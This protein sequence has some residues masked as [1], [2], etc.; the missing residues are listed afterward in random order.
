[1]TG[2]EIGGVT[3]F[4][5][6]AELP[7]WID[8][9][10]MDA[11]ADR[12]R[13]RQPQLEGHRPASILLTLPGAEVVEGLANPAPPPADGAARCRRRR[14]DH[15]WASR[16]ARG[17]RVA[18]LVRRL[19]GVIVLF[20]RRRRRSAAGLASPIAHG[21]GVRRRDRASAATDEPDA[22]S[23][24]PIDRATRPSRAERREPTAEADRCRRARPGRRSRSRR[25]SSTPGRPGRPRP[26]DHLQRPGRR[27]RSGA[28][29]VRHAAGEPDVPAIRRSA[30]RLP[31]DRRRLDHR[32]HV[33]QGA[34]LHAHAA[35]R[36]D[37]GARRR[38]DPDVPRASGPR[39]PS[40]TPASTARLPRDRTAS[41]WWSRRAPTATCG[42]SPSGAAIRSVYEIDLLGSRAGPAIAR[43]ARP[44]AGDGRRTPVRGDGAA[45]RGSL[46]LQNAETGFGITP[47]DRADHLA[48][49]SGPTGPSA[50]RV[51]TAGP[52]CGQRPSPRGWGPS[53]RSPMSRHVAGVPRPRS[54]S[55]NAHRHSSLSRHSPTA[56]MPRARV[57]ARRHGRRPPRALEPP[58]PLP[59]YHPRFVTET[60]E[61]PMIDCLWASGAMLL[62]KWTNGDIH[63][64][65]QRLRALSGDAP[66]GSEFSRPEDR[67]PQ[68]RLQPQ[69]LARWRRTGSRSPACSAARARAPA[70]SC[71]ATT[72]S[73]PATS[74][75]GTTRSGT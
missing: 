14:P 34:V 33:D 27:A 63:P 52:W 2:H 18:V 64:T 15:R 29:D 75:A 11:G 8:A 7:V 26:R 28:L 31:D 20:G 58:R 61:R 24:A 47:T 43:A 45:T 62:D 3:V 54:D 1:M 69:V 16:P 56:T 13:R 59:G 35:G 65:H 23:R 73:C 41:R 70:R 51:G 12:A 60:D 67:L 17:R 57:A 21:A 46:V 44:G 25:S 9:A 48:L 50:G 39:S 72:T 36:R 10:V 37:R 55:Q 38:R 30:T 4:G 22:P 74:A 40:T 42:S 53:P 6:P 32:G 49:T 68:A 66:G 5:L 19:L 71:W